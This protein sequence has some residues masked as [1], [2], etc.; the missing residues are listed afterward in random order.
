M[1]VGKMNTK[2]RDKTFER[3]QE[4]NEEMRD[5]IKDIF[6]DLKLEE[7]ADDLWELINGLIENELQQEELCGE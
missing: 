2:E 6:G 3:L 1:R 5:K 4:E 7:T